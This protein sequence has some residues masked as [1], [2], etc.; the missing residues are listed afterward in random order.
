MV[1]IPLRMVVSVLNMYRLPF[2]VFVTGGVVLVVEVVATR[3]LAPYF[4]NTIFT[5]SSVLSVIL[6]ALSIG[7]A[8]GG[9]LSD[10]YP[11]E[12]LFAFIIAAS[13]LSI[14]LVYLCVVLIL[15]LAAHSLDIVSGP[16]IV[17]SGLFFL[18]ACLLGLLSPFA[19]NLQ[20]RL[21][22]EAGIGTISGRIFF[23]STA[24]SII[25]SLGTG[26]FLIPHFG[27]NAILIGVVV[28]LLGLGAALLLMAQVRGSVVGGLL[29]I[30]ILGAIFAP[31]MG[32][33]LSLYGQETRYQKVNVVDGQYDNRPARFFLQ[34]HTPSGAIY[35]ESDEPVFE[36]VKYAALY[37]VL[38]P[39]IHR[40]LI[41][42]GGAYNIPKKLLQDVP[43]IQV[44]VAEID[45]ALQP[46]AERYFGLKSD[47]RL[48][49][50]VVDG[51]QFLHG[52]EVRYDLIYSDVY[53]SFSIPM[54]LATAEFF[55]A[56][57]AKLN[58]KGFFLGN[59][60]G[61]LVADDGQSFLLSEMRTFQEIFPNSY[62]FLTEPDHPTEGQNVI[63]LGFKHSTPIDFNGS[64]FTSQTDPFLRSLKGKLIDTA[65][66]DLTR[67]PKLTDNYAP[68]EY[69]I[70]RL[71][72]KTQGTRPLSLSA[73]HSK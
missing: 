50:H 47:N 54:H 73:Q 15:P 62:F 6:A 53:Y 49:H 14:Y 21:T 1:I 20:S 2:A 67:Y 33:D 32:P 13:G 46:I 16:L 66:L 9:R 39:D 36:S 38:Y 48:I 60:I 57:R 10:R 44:D 29:C 40:A 45:P 23:W 34:D 18:P 8:I 64:L 52:T 24:G 69:L 25:G 42:G 5:F 27:V 26:F 63:F 51:R 61:R 7:Y 71:V 68:V 35:L 37:R 28:L 72:A 59:F 17:S 22:P 30:G 4:G 41:I 58:D 65:P 12:R 11:N 55:E 70:G 19:I 56:A 31:A 43:N 3:I